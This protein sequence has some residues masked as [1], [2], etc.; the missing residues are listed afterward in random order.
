M[1]WTNEIPASSGFYWI[2]TDDGHKGV[3]RVDVDKIQT[4][5]EWGDAVPLVYVEGK[6][7]ETGIDQFVTDRGKSLK[8]SGPIIP[9][10]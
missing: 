7:G 10:E 3:V 8:W 1:K 9:P 4:E 5:T 6:S 2:K